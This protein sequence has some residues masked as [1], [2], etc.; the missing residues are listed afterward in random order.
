MRP[1]YRRVVIKPLGSVADLL[2]VGSVAAAE[3]KLRIVSSSSPSPLSEVLIVDD[4]ADTREVLSEFCRTLGLTVSTVSDGK[5]AL[6]AIERSPAQY[7]VVL[8]DICMPDVDGFDVLKAIRSVNPSSYVVMI[9]GYA[10]LDSALRAVH[11]GA[12][13]YLPKPFALGQLEV[14]LSR[15]RDRINLEDE[16]RSLLRQVDGLR[17]GTLAASHHSMSWRL[18]AIE[19]RLGRIEDLL[20][21]R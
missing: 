12:Y 4:D 9:T 21:S 18:G 20:R 3:V 14:V 2:F 5:A 7:K 6:A 8:T 15:I 11:E 10:T 16:N 1:A 19:E 17:E 13:D